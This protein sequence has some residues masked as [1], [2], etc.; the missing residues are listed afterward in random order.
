[1]HLDVYLCYIA[2][3]VAVPCSLNFKFCMPDFFLFSL[4]FD[5]GRE[6]QD[7]LE[8]VGHAKL[9]IQST[10]K[11]NQSN[12]ALDSAAKCIRSDVWEAAELSLMHSTRMLTCVV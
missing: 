7:E 2:F 9:K 10:S 4:H 11:S 12:A 6:V 5:I 8:K 1:M 3:L